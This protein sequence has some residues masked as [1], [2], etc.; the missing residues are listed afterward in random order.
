VR[1]AP[2]PRCFSFREDTP[3]RQFMNKLR[4]QMR[5]ISSEGIMEEKF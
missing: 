2:A 5:L 3:S 1:R 4:R